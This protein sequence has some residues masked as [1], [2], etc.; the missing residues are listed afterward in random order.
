VTAQINL[1]YCS[2][3]ISSQ[4]TFFRSAILERR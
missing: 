1:R 2:S 4:S 3:P